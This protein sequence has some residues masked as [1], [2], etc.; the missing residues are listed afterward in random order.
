MLSDWPKKPALNTDSFKA[1]TT[2]TSLSKR[3]C[4]SGPSSMV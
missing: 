3:S 2:R 1:I 4:D